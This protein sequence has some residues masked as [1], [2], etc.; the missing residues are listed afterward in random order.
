MSVSTG[1]TPLP[2]IVSLLLWALA[3][4]HLGVGAV[5]LIAPGAATRLVGVLY[6]ARLDDSPQLR[7]ATVMIGALAIAIGIVAVGAA[8]AP[9]AHRSV[10]GALLV[11]QLA[12]LVSRVR[13]RRL[14]ATA[15][16]VTPARNAGMIAVLGLEIAVLALA[17]W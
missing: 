2:A 10:I 17:L 1:V 6:G 4:Y 14:L 16:G 11:L 5:A 9:V 8:R 7:Y 15:F 3:L 12:R 13:H